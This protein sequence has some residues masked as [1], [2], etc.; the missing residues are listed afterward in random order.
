MATASV[1]NTF[2]EGAVTSASTMNQNFTDI[3]TFLNSDTVHV[4]GSKTM[5]GDLDM[6]GFTISSVGDPSAST[7]AVTKSFVDNAVQGA[8][9]YADSPVSLTNTVPVNFTSVVGD[10]DGWWDSEV[11]A[12]DLICP[13]SGI[14]FV[15]IRCTTGYVGTIPARVQFQKKESSGSLYKTVQMRGRYTGGYVW[16][17]WCIMVA[18]AGQYFRAVPIFTGSA[19]DLEVRIQ[20]LGEF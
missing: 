17:T 12:T 13:T 16:N 7:D 11:S 20:K 1:T 14:Y 15:R 2:V 5:T 6:N 19:T 4:D 8:V 3:E 18:N 10:V 9:F